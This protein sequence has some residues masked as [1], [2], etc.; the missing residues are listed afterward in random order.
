MKVN[1]VIKSVKQ[2][3]VTSNGSKRWTILLEGDDRIFS[4]FEDQFKRGL[5]T[6]Q[7]IQATVEEKTYRNR[8]YFNLKNI[9]ATKTKEAPKN[10]PQTNGDNR[11][12]LMVLSYAKD[13]T[14]EVAKKTD[15]TMGTDEIVA[16]WTRY[17]DEGLK[18]VSGGD[19]VP[20]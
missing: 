18:L 15:G 11:E 19:D 2:G 20:F 12:R 13:L 8:T 17:F 3:E 9:R 16:L 5:K 14:V 6:G 10:R 4:V 1:G 7:E